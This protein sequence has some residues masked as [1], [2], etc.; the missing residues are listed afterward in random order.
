MNYKSKV[1]KLYKYKQVTSHVERDFTNNE[2]LL[3]LLRISQNATTFKI[4]EIKV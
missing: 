3:N 1:D 2:I 4:W